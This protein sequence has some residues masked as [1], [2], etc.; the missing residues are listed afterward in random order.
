MSL[1]RFD[2]L[3]QIMFL[4]L[5]RHESSSQ[6]AVFSSKQVDVLPGIHQLPLQQ[7]YAPLGVHELAL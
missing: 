2:S 4:L 6:A 3:L 1:Q 5:H 7:F